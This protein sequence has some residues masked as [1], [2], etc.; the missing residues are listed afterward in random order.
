MKVLDFQYYQVEIKKDSELSPSETQSIL[1]LYNL[2]FYDNQIFNPNQL[3][4]L[5]DCINARDIFYWFL[6]KNPQGQL[7]GMVSLVHNYSQAYLFDI[8]STLGE[9]ICSLAIDPEFRGKGLATHLMQQV[10][11]QSKSYCGLRPQDDL[12]LE[13]KKDSRYYSQLNHLY[14]GL[15]FKHFQ[16]TEQGWF[17]KL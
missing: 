10:I 3:N 13:I 9:N 11:S 14:C 5:R 17:L 15:G 6:L 12:V 16:E 1:E 4:F 8:N 7:L 2:S